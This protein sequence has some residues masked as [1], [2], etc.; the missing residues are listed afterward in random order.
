MRQEILKSHI[1]RLVPDF[2]QGS[3]LGGHISMIFGT[4]SVLKISLSVG[5]SFLRQ[6]LCC[7]VCCW[8][9]YIVAPVACGDLVFGLCFVMQY[10][11]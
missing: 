3:F 5:L 9:L 8:S 7:C 1:N 6:W 2:F 4:E 10:Y 11:L